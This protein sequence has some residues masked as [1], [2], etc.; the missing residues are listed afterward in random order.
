MRWI[1]A[2]LM[3]A[4]LGCGGSTLPPTHEVTGTVSDA[5][6]KP[7]N[8]GMVQFTSPA[9]STLTV[10]GMIA[11]DGKYALKTAQGRNLGQGA[12]EGE[13]KVT[14]IPPI[15]SDQTGA[16][17]SELPGL[18]RVKAGANRIDLRVGTPPKSGS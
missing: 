18:A 13:Y 12:P 5:K 15:S 8:G 16:P 11:S 2:G 4:I 17:P 6:G 9:D 1:L 7:Y 10:T 3:L 14:L